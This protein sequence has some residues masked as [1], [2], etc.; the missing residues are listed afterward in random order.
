M[1]NKKSISHGTDFE[2]LCKYFTLSKSLIV[3]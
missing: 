1:E 2:A 3:T